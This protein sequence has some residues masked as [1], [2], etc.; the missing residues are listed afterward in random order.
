VPI[1]RSY[2]REV[3]KVELENI[4]I[5]G[6]TMKLGSLLAMIFLS[7]VA[8]VHLLRL[9]FGVAFI[10]GDTAIPMWASIFAVIGPGIIALLLWKEKETAA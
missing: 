4:S 2:D 10:V 8:F 9:I 6:I 1:T 3:E 7:I 5:G